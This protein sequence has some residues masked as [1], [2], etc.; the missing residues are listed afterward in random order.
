MKGK[1]GK[2][3][4][5]EIATRDIIRAADG[6]KV[7]HDYNW[8]RSDGTY[9]LEEWAYWAYPFSQG[10]G[11]FR[12]K[13]D[14]KCNFVDADGNL[15]SGK[16]FDDAVSF[17]KTKGDP[18]AVQVGW[19]DH[20]GWHALYGRKADGTPDLSEGSTKGDPDV[21]SC[22]LSVVTY[23]P[24]GSRYSD[25]YYCKGYV[26]A[27]MNTVGCMP[28]IFQHKDFPFDKADSFDESRYGG[29]WAEVRKD[30]Y[31][32]KNLMSKDGTLLE[33]GSPTSYE[34][35][36]V[37]GQDEGGRRS[38]TVYYRGTGAEYAF[39]A[40]KGWTEI[41]RIGVGKADWDSHLDG[42][43][44]RL[45]L[46]DAWDRVADTVAHGCIAARDSTG[47]DHFVCTL[48]GKWLLPENGKG[49]Q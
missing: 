29:R 33:F 12:R 34:S 4:T 42:E 47:A 40:S 32:V 41:D 38:L 44:G 26:D 3:G 36:D 37:E 2:G 11:M 28:E 45:A 49:L 25:Y 30:G 10:W 17:G 20:I 46:G 5:P 18:A 24:N 7:G 14:E 43:G 48:D 19:G 8:I 27:S 1:P 23:Y 16:W 6:E 35:V 21:F 13:E 15:L 9:V 39:P 31:K 22:G